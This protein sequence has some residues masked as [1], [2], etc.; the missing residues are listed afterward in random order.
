MRPSRLLQNVLPATLLASSLF[1]AA[2]IQERIKAK[3]ATDFPSL[4]QNAGRA[5][6]DGRYGACI[7]GLK[8]CVELAV[9][10]R[11]EAIRAALPGAL[12]GWRVQEQR[13]AQPNPF[14]TAMATTVGNVVE[15][16][17]REVNGRN[18][19]TVTVTADSPMV[20]MV[21]MAIANP[22]LDPEAE[23][24]RYGAHKAI[25]K[26]HGQG[27]NLQILIA[28]KHLVDVKTS[29][30]DEDFLFR[31]FDQRVVDRLAAALAS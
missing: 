29:M 3:D 12:D 5:F 10:K 26:K 16:T 17:Y 31:L 1:L 22:A 9:Q 2:P 11:T 6:Q 24:I 25:L 19:V 18:S 14:A 8:D 15:E 30:D 27:L 20:G 7:A 13:K 28:E 21:S 4:L 23:G